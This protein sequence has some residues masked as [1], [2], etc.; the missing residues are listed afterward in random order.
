M[1]HDAPAPSDAPS[2]DASVPSSAASPDPSASAPSIGLPLVLIVLGLLVGIGAFAAHFGQFDLSAALAANLGED[3]IFEDDDEEPLPLIGFA[4]DS[5]FMFSGLPQ[6]PDQMYPAVAASVFLADPNEA[7]FAQQPRSVREF[8]Q[9][10]DLYEKRQGQDDNFTIRVFDGRSNETL[11]L[12]EL[13]AERTRYEDSGWANW[14]RIN[15]VRRTETRRLV[16][17]YVRRGIPREEVKIRWGYANQVAE[18]RARELSTIQYEIALADQLGLSLLATEIGTVETFNQDMLVSPAGARSRYQMMPDVLR[19]FDVRRYQLPAGEGRVDVREEHH[20][21]LTL[22]PAFVFLRGYVNS[23]GHE[24]PGISAYHTGPGNIFRLYQAYMQSQAGRSLDHKSV[25]DA[26]MWGV[27][28]GFERVKRQSSFG[29]HSRAYVLQAYGSLRATE[30]ELIDPTQ[31]LEAERV[32]LIAGERITLA[33]LLAR[34]DAHSDRLDWSTVADLGS[35]YERFRA[36]N[37]HIDLPAS[38][39]GAVPPRGNLSLTAAV[40]EAPVQFFLPLGASDLLARTG[41]TLLD[42]AATFVFDRNAFRT[43]AADRTAADDAYDRLVA[44]IAAFGFTE[45]NLARLRTLRG[46]FY[47]LAEATPTAY[48]QRQAEIIRI[49]S[50]VW[51]TR[52]WRDLV[53]SVSTV[54]GAEAGLPFADDVASN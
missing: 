44:D 29:N 7:S 5:P 18:A 43:S 36:L 17:K 28:D 50:Q 30:D 52:A 9:L 45:S 42:P 35:S 11:E 49:H 12:H 3:G 33:D 26:Y 46:Q 48:R 15:Q 51:G 16:D 47:A 40:G 2:P 19:R 23:V 27:T 39:D 6:H 32:R 25:V 20:P 22:E 10:L 14:D 53:G 1:H 24:I 31:T 13:V 41:R 21:L 38:D 34:L 8:R 4:P 54:M 37:P